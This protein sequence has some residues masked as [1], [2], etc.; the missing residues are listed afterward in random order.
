MVITFPMISSPGGDS[1]SNARTVEEIHKCALKGGFT[2]GLKGY[3]PLR[4]RP[5]SMENNLYEFQR[6]RHNLKSTRAR[7][8]ERRKE[9]C[10]T[11]LRT[12]LHCY[13]IV[14]LVLGLGVLGIGIWLLVT[15]YN[16][17][18]VSVLIGSNLFEVGTYLMIAGGGAIALLAFC[19]CCGTMKEDRC[20]LAF[21]GVT[22]M[23][24]LMALCVGSGVAFVFRGFLTEKV[25]ENFIHT[26]TKNYGVDT[27]KSSQNRLITDAWDSMQRR[28]QCCGVHGDVHSLYS[29][30]IYGSQSE[31]YQQITGKAPYVPDSCCKEN[32]DKQICTGTFPINGPPAKKPPL[33]HD[34]VMNDHLNTDGCY[35]KVI[36]HLQK[37]ALILGAVAACVPVLLI[38][39]I[40]IVFCLCARVQRNEDDE[41]YV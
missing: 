32:G 1:S 36:V 40:I 41:N 5:P 30:N 26:L 21:Y 20:V 6:V 15:D 39:G 25:K 12:A 16:A 11:C 22:L 10:Y 4:K 28:L 23:I 31:W 24:V 13:N 3:A 8:P 37:H 35:D 27:R 7:S 29:W 17:R 9:P 34:N 33:L 14:I 38:F 18:E 2:Y 19:G